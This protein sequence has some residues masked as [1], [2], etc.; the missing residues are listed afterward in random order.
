MRG[1]NKLKCIPPSASQSSQA[2]GKETP[3]ATHPWCRCCVWG[4]WG[5]AVLAVPC[6]KQLSSGVGD[7]AL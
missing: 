5:V 1:K 2:G 3:K 4:W 6:L 7:S